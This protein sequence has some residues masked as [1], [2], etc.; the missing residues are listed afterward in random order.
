MIQRLIQD[1]SFD[2]TFRHG[3]YTSVTGGGGT[4]SSPLFF[5]TNVHEN[6]LQRSAFGTFLNQMRLITVGDWVVTVHTAGELYR[7]VQ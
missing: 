7:Y 1:T 4:S 2:N 3:V 6:R 5:A